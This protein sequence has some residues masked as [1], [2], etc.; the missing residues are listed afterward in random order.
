MNCIHIFS[1][2]E[3]K[4]AEVERWNEMPFNIIIMN[5][6]CIHIFSLQENK[7]AEVE[8]WNGMPSTQ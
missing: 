3:N 5:M 6:N 8:R 7:A 2:Q 1:L 4:A